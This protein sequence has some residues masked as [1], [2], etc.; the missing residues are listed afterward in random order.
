[1]HSIM[2]MNAWVGQFLEADLCGWR[3]GYGAYRIYTTHSP[4]SFDGLSFAEGVV[5]VT[6]CFVW[7]VS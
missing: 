2:V 3:L 5:A 4:P 7:D 6:S 1:M